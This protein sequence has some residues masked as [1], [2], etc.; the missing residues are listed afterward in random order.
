LWGIFV[1]YFATCSCYTVIIA[2]NFNFVAEHYLGPGS[3]NLRATIAMLL[4]PLILLAFVPNL[5]YLAPVSM[6]A[7]ACMA[8]GLGITFYYLVNELPP[9]TERPAVASITTLPIC[10]SVVIFAIEAI[11]VVMPLENN[12]STPRSF[13]GV[14]RRPQPGHEFRDSRLHHPGILRVLEVRE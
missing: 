11:G 12:M 5:K 3:T 9:I 13:V 7:N 6:V 8:V 1:T 14:V 10:I 2:K 4:V